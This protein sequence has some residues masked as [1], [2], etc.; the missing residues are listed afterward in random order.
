VEL[1]DDVYITGNGSLVLLSGASL[2]CEKYVHAGLL[3]ASG[4]ARRAS[5]RACGRSGWRRAG[6]AE[7]ELRRQ[8][9]GGC[10][11]LAGAVY[12]PGLIVGTDIYI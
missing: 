4:S 6:F 10:Y 11:A 7:R 3:R 9:S 12:K 8:R 5:W 1:D 2:T